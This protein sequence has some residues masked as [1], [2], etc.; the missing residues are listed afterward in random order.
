MRLIV[1]EMHLTFLPLSF[2]M[3]ALRVASTI[4]PGADSREWGHRHAIAG[5]S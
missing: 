4:P 5:A 3:M 2:Q 1:T